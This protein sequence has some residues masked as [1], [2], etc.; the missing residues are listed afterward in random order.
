MGLVW[1][2][3]GEYSSNYLQEGKLPSLYVL[4]ASVRDPDSL[5]LL[6]SLPGKMSRLGKGVACGETSTL[7]TEALVQLELA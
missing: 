2:A 5:V 4:R 1:K 7:N 6:G 3:G